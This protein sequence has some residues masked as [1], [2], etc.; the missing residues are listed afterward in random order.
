MR[1]IHIEKDDLGYAYMYYRNFEIKYV[2]G[3]FCES[4]S[5][6]IRNTSTNAEPETEYYT[7]STVQI[8]TSANSKK[9][10]CTL[11]I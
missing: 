11:G 6:H 10:Q 1:N 7:V 9:T 8:A 2:S 4:E 5:C 3:R